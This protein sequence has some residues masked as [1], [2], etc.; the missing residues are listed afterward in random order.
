MDIVDAHF[1]MR[2]R[3]VKCPTRFYPSFAFIFDD[4]VFK[5]H[6]LFV[7]RKEIHKR[8]GIGSNENQKKAW[9]PVF[10]VFYA[11]IVRHIGTSLAFVKVAD[12]VFRLILAHKYFR[13]HEH[14]RDKK[15]YLA[16]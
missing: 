9:Q 3:T 6:F 13:A 15:K 2:S 5:R 14:F 10:E 16:V 1:V 12:R 8:K 7:I 4:F 11:S